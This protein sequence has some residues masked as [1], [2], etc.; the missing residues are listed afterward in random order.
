MDWFLKTA[1][2][3]HPEAQS[4]IGDLYTNG[5]RASQDY[6]QAIERY[7]K[8]ANKGL[9]R[10]Q[11]NMGDRYYHGEE[12]SPDYSQAIKQWTG[13]FEHPTR[14]MHPPNTMSAVCTGTGSLYLRNTSKQW[15]G[16]SR[17]PVKGMQTLSSMS[18]FSKVQRRRRVG[19]RFRHKRQRGEEWKSEKERSERR[20]GMNV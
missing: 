11:I 13:T 17:Q 2:Q 7:Q 20:D 16:T 1:A 9:S 19:N 10:A 5:Q 18:A 8:A 15:I 3:D 4:S 14:D 6:T 12:V